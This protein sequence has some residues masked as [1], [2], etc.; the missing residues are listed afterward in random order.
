MARG[1]S[2]LATAVSRATLATMLA[3]G[4]IGG[5]F[6]RTTP[7]NAEP[8][9]TQPSYRGDCRQPPAGSTCLQF[10]DGYIW[11]VQD[12]IAGWGA[13]HGTIEMAYGQVADYAHAL[14]TEIV[15]VL[16]PGR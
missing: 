7:A 3:A 16:P 10:S 6:R 11:L 9:T 5:A 12:T 1:W 15:W 4:L 8:S 2:R 14:G 13:N